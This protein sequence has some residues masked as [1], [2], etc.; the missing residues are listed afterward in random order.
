MMYQDRLAV[1]IK[2]NGKVLREF[3]DTVYVPYGSEYSIF[4]KNLN[5][6]RAMV[7]LSVDGQDATESVSLIVQPN[8]SI[9]VERFIKAGNL[10][11]GNRFKFIERTKQVEDGP[12]GIGAEDGLIRVEFEFERETEK[13]KNWE[14]DRT[15]PYNPSWPKPY[16]YVGSPVYNSGTTGSVFRGEVKTSAMAN[17]VNASS[18]QSAFGNAAG[19]FADTSATYTASASTEAPKND[20]GITVP[21]SVSEQR[22]HQASSFATDGQKHVMVLKL[23]GEVKVQERTVFTV[24]VGDMSPEEAKRYLEKVAQQVKSRRVTQP[25]TVKTTQK[26]TT[27]GHVNKATAKFCS[28]CGTG[29]TLV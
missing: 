14:W 29:L 23:L 17:A 1:A 2:V 10:A 7:R 12:R 13:L 16:W 3:K 5:S 22:F 11:A 6:L 26:C 18:Q 27:C 21:G 19:T 25:V 9:E 15:P 24:D 28:E 20:V 4:I 8:D